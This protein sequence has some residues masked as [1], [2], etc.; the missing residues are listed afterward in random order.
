MTRDYVK[1]APAL[2]AG[3]RRA[4][5]L[6]EAH[7]ELARPAVLADG[8]LRWWLYSYECPDGVPAMVAAIRRAVGGKWDKAETPGIGEPEMTFSRKGYAITVKREAVCVR[9]VVGTET[10][11]LPAVE[12]APERTV[13][14]EIVEWD[15][16]PILTAVPA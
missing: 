13:D 9:R 7:P 4:A 8:D 10:V 5:D 14:R 15:C 3:F 2:I 16:E 11:T 1:T 12:A 6:I